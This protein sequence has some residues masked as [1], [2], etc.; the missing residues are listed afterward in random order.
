[1]DSMGN[2]IYYNNGVGTYSDGTP[3]IPN[4]PYSG[5][6]NYGGST[7]GYGSTGGTTATST[8]NKWAD[9]EDWVAKYGANSINDYLGEHYKEFGY[10]S[11]S[12]AIAGWKNHLTETGAGTS[13][14]ARSSGSTGSGGNYSRYST[15]SA[16]QSTG[17]GTGS[18]AASK[19]TSASQLGETAKNIIN[20][21]NPDPNY[22]AT[23][24]QKGLKNGTVTEAE[25]DFL[26]R[27]VGY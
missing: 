19:I 6:Y 8:W 24:V 9:A 25:A 18:S 26:L 14:S 11:K 20:H 7:V 17:T 1:V 27:Q 16:P 22:V 5:G 2:T 21:I 23:Q 15:Y 3:Y 12:T 13:S 10:K 4:L